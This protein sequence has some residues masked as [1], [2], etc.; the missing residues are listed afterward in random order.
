MAALRFSAAT[1]IVIIMQPVSHMLMPVP[2]PAQ[3]QPANGFAPKLS[4]KA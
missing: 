4:R 2:L 1:S 3:A